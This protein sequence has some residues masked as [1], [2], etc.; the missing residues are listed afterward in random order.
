M[1]V[2]IAELRWMLL[3]G[4]IAALF[5]VVVLR[6]FSEAALWLIGLMLGLDLIF[7]GVSWLMLSLA[8]RAL[9]QLEQAPHRY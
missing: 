5:G 2:R 1:W 4:L 6:H 3:S 8:V 7:S 9:V